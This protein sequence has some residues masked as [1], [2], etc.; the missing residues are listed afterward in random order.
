MQVWSRNCS[1]VHP[2]SVATCGSSSP[3]A[4]AVFHDEPVTAHVHRGWIGHGLE[5]REDRDFERESG[6]VGPRERREPRVAECRRTGRSSGRPVPSGSPASGSPTHP[7]S[8]RLT[9]TVTK[10]LPG[11]SNTGR[12]F[13][14][15]DAC[16]A[17]P[18]FDR[19]RARGAS[20]AA[21]SAS[22]RSGRSCGGCV[23]REFPERRAHVPDDL[24]CV[25]RDVA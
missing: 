18:G 25:A 9:K 1:R 8:A 2:C 21:R 16:Y 23:I 14:L 3:R 24:P 22:S 4:P 7:C 11:R 15:A 13:R 5:R 10:A 17:Q 6:Q 20:R 12:W 19:R